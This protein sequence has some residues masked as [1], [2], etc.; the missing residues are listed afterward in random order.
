[1]M[2][3]VCAMFEFLSYWAA[4]AKQPIAIVLIAHVVKMS[5]D[6]S[7]GTIWQGFDIRCRG[8]VLGQ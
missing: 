4:S 2:S 1:M 6:L 7:G 5:S 3:V 8:F